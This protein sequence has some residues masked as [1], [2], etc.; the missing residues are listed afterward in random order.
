MAVL[1]VLF[2]I[3]FLSPGE[4]KISVVSIPDKDLKALSRSFG[5][6]PMNSMQ[7]NWSEK[8]FEK[9]LQLAFRKN[10][11]CAALDL[12]EESAQISPAITFSAGMRSLL[13]FVGEDKAAL[14]VSFGDARSPLF[15]A[16]VS[17]T[18]LDA[19]S[20][21]IRFLEALLLSG[22]LDWPE[23]AGNSK[24]SME[25]ALEILEKLGF[26]DPE[27][28]VIF[29]FIGQV[30][31]FL[32]RSKEEVREAYTLASKTT[33]FNPYYQDLYDQ[34]LKISYKNVATF[35]FVHRFLEAAPSP[36]YNEGLRYIRYWAQSEEP[37]KWVANRISKKLIELG[38]K[39]KKESP[40]YLY[41]QKEYV[42][43]QNLKLTVEGRPEKD[44]ESYVNK[45]KE[46]KDFM[47]D[48]PPQARLAQAGLL[49]SVLSNKKNSC[50][51]QVWKQLY[52]AYK[53]KKGI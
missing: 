25:R 42:E 43:G 44:W 23:G 17:G 5:S 8:D 39:H 41:Q 16:G 53:N 27:N 11:P 2:G 10:N 51:S 22:N 1:L 50:D 37:G 45:M 52:E 33:K 13:T 47:S 35:A 40:G 26:E 9:E 20:A 48:W 14:L 34:L 3:Y 36:N 15:G 4:E 19:T 28:G 12:M 46:A 21:S 29:Y 7:R 31:R 38:E 32:G 6:L 30:K 18:E 49:Q 24:R